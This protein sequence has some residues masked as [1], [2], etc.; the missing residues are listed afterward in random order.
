MDELLAGALAAIAEVLVDAV[1]EIAG[2]ALAS[3]LTRAISSLF[4]TVSDLNPVATTLA[5]GTFGFGL[6]ALSG[7][8]LSIY[9]FTFS[10]KR[11]QNRRLSP[12]FDT[13]PSSPNDR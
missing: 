4:R 5:L 2:E 7:I 8:C 1:F 9:F 13:G 12:S 6:R 3:L 10:M 11:S